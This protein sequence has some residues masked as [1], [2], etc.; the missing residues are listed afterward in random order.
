MSGPILSPTGRR[1]AREE[2]ITSRRDFGILTIYASLFIIYYLLFIIY[3]LLFIIYYSIFNIYYS[4][5]LIVAWHM[6]SM[7]GILAGGGLLYH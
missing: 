4:S 6:G 3:Y 1:A 2:P 7:M 5:L